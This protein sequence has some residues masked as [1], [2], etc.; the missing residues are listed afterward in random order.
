MTSFESNG[1][2]SP[3]K[4]IFR[5][6]SLVFL[7]AIVLLTLNWF[8]FPISKLDTSS[9]IAI[10]K[11]MNSNELGNLLQKSGYRLSS[12]DFK[13]LSAVMR[14]DRSLKAGE[15]TVAHDMTLYQLIKLFK[16]GEVNKY[17]VTIVEGWT[18]T[19]L[20][21]ELHDTDKI[22]RTSGIDSTNKI[23]ILK[24]DSTV[25]N[26][27]GLLLPDTYQYEYGDTDVKIILRAYKQ[28]HDYLK[29]AW[30]TRGTN[31]S[32]KTPYEA[33]ILA[34]IVEKETSL[35]SEL[36]IVSG[37]YQERLR[38]N[39][40]LQA[41]PTVNY[42]LGGDYSH[43]LSRTDLKIDS[44]FNTYQNKGL[45][46]SPI[47]FPS[48]SAIDAVLHPIDKPPLYFVADGKGGHVFSH[49]YSD[50]QKAVQEYRNR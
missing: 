6:L 33:L 42:A 10:A 45:P 34:S 29:E 28:M 26:Y 21:N 15:Y 20:L 49:S 48:R 2:D 31:I 38:R 22:K 23:G 50:H 24:I 40:R 46:P 27:E 8:Y 13:F 1:L 17:N 36:I 37:V 12:Q 30:L 5:T 11:G 14:A 44:P 18:I 19:D 41:D 7:V 47:A 16:K 25:K 35:K 3:I 4:I 39:W 32:V 9:T 43:K